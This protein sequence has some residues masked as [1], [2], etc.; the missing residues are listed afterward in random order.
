[1]VPCRWRKPGAYQLA[2]APKLAPSKAMHDIEFTYSRRMTS[3]DHPAL[4][5]GAPGKLYG[6]SEESLDAY[7]A[8]V[9]AG[10]V[11]TIAR[12][13]LEIRVGRREG[14]RFWDA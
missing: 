14:A 11:D 10:H 7:P 4:N 6:S 9:S 8:A 13:E 3:S 12:M 1:M 5:S 2:Q